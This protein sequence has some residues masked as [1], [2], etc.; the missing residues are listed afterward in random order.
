MIYWRLIPFFRPALAFAAGCFSYKTEM[1]WPSL[2][3]IACS[4]LIILLLEK[5]S[6][7]KTLN[8]TKP[9]FLGS[10]IL[11]IFFAAG[12]TRSAIHDQALEN[13]TLWQNSRSIKA[14]SIVLTEPVIRNQT[15]VTV[16][17]ISFI[18]ADKRYSCDA[19]LVLYIKNYRNNHPIEI[20]DT[21]IFSGTPLPI[22]PPG[23]PYAFDYKKYMS[24][25]NI[26]YQ[27]FTEADSVTL[28]S[29]GCFFEPA[30][31]A[32]S[33][34]NYISAAY[35]KYIPDGPEKSLI[36]ALIL[37]MQ[38]EMPDEIKN[39]YIITGAV[40]VLSVSGLHVAIAAGIITGI[41]S[42]VPGRKKGARAWIT[43]IL[44][45]IAI[46]AY[47]WIT[48]A[49]PPA[50]RSA[51][52]CIFLVTGLMAGLKIH[53][54]NLLSVAAFILLVIDPFS[55]MDIGFQFSFLALL[56]IIVFNNAV[57]NALHP[58]NFLTL[59]AWKNIS[60]GISAQ[61]LTFPLTLYYFHQFPVYFWLSGLVA[62]FLAEWIL[63][64]GFCL[65]FLHCIE[66][67]LEKMGVVF[68]SI[69]PTLI[70]KLLFGL[71]YLQNAGIIL[72]SRLPAVLVKDIWISSFEMVVLTAFSIAVFG[73]IFWK[74][75]F[76]IFSSLTLLPVFLSSYGLRIF[77]R[78]GVDT[79][80]IYDIPRGTA[81]D[82][83][84]GGDV[85]SFSN[86]DLPADKTEQAASNWRTYLGAYQTSS[87][88]IRD[89][90]FC[91]ESICQKNNVFILGKLV[92]WLPSTGES[93]T[94][95]PVDFILVQNNIL[96]SDLSLKSNHQ[97][98]EI[99]LDKT[100][101]TQI[102]KAWNVFANTRKI[103]LHDISEKGA[104]IYQYHPN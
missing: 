59:S 12:F 77:E 91:R 90:I 54:V 93:N 95:Q 49:S 58:K 89:S 42:L 86:M 87:F 97:V 99:I 44:A 52:M 70:G 39:A 23:N 101:K 45:C 62:V 60:M 96:P 57:L 85:V 92:L 64:G 73:W 104:F 94:S 41:F 68:F 48:G 88:K 43:T 71:A 74:G 13:N 67:L 8:G 35:S 33:V 14:L 102:R 103:P 72:T 75:K 4:S 50:L 27:C 3:I 6:A 83:I 79:L 26:Y 46:L 65:F 53:A 7:F 32:C 1:G 2:C 9:A 34:R 19:N 22:R 55:I 28:H 5:Y 80:T 78:I 16:N 25:K 11:F 63:K 98:K 17:V 37:G 36:D 24:V 38:N 66:L 30:R 76:W 18:S 82:Y 20:G 61:V 56:S 40:H 69:V 15:R 84:S 21:I 51:V 47:A 29:S 10:L 81:F 31:W 100:N